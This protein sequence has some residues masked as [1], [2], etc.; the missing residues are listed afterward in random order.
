MSR[1]AT[2]SH[3]QSVDIEL[4][5]KAKRLSAIDAKIA[6]DPALAAARKEMEAEAAALATARKSL[7]EREFESKRVDS[8]IMDLEERLYSGRV[9]NPKELDGLER[10]LQMLKRQRSDLEDQVLQQMEQVDQGQ[11]RVAARETALKAVQG[12]RASQLDQL[13]RERDQLLARLKTLE[14]EEAN[15]RSELDPESLRAYDHLRRTK[16]NRA[17]SLVRR[18]ACSTCGV[19]VPTGLKQRI[20]TGDELVFCS[21]CGR[22]LS[23]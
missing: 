3:L 5:E 11:S 19:S 4:D 20:H 2:L 9:Q 21:G 1:L 22:I 16:A 15:D 12:T 13:A 10:E 17:V 6:S 23:G 18:D 8:K 7:A 14:D